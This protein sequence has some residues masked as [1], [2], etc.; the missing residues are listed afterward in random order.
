MPL[1]KTSSLL[2]FALL[3]SI[4]STLSILQAANPA[5]ATVGNNTVKG[6]LHCHPNNPFAF[7]RP[8][9]QDCI[10]AVRRLPSSH[11]HGRFHASGTGDDRFAL[12]V[13]KS[14]G[15]CQVV[16]QLR[17]PR[18]ED[19]TWLGL[20]LAATQLTT[21]CTDRE[22]YLP[23]RGGWT[24][25]GDNDMIRITVQSSKQMLDVSGNETTMDEDA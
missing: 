12:P 25:A 17:G 8:S 4:S 21:A 16:V 10:S 3:T 18:T 23:K 14:C 2:L 15:L 11:I 19:G 24:D 20:N 1:A 22:G 6:E 9:A 13:L 7:A 5:I